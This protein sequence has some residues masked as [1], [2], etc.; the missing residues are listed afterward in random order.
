MSEICER[1]LAVVRTLDTAG[2]KLEGQKLTGYAIV[3]NAT[4]AGP[5]AVGGIHL[6]ERIDPGAFS[7]S[8]RDNIPFTFSHKDFAEY[9]D[10]RS[11]SL[12]LSDD[13]K[14]IKFELDLPAYAN[15]LRQQIECGAIRGMSFGFEVKDMQIKNNVRHIV[16]GVLL[17]ISPVYSPAYPQTSVELVR[18]INHELKKKRLQLLDLKIKGLDIGNLRS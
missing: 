9:G 4:T 17:H 10:T 7:D 2:L 3:Y 12:R 5:V 11:G 15:V 1:T 16:K 6:L 8:L 14:G 18:A 13:D